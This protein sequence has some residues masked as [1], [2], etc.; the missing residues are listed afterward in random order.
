M[1]RTIPNLLLC[2]ALLGCPD[3]GD[4]DTP[5]GTKRFTRRESHGAGMDLG[6]GGVAVHVVG[7]VVVV[8]V[9]QQVPVGTARRGQHEEEEVSQHPCSGVRL[10]SRSSQSQPP[11][12]YCTGS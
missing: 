10:R 4:D 7:V 2:L 3:P 6:I 1:L 11:M 8:V 9:V 5:K 12:G